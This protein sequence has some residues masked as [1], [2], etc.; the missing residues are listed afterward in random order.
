[1]E[2]LF[3]LAVTLD[4]VAAVVDQYCCS[5][6]N[7]ADAVPAASGPGQGCEAFERFRPVFDRQIQP[8][9]KKKIAQIVLASTTNNSILLG[10]P[11]C[12]VSLQW[13]WVLCAL[14]CLCRG[15][16]SQ[17]CQASGLVAFEA[18]VI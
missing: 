8:E 15:D 2:L 16:S 6:W 11:V 3:V 7:S 12:K 9:F 13:S 18:P 5:L 1:M 10:F 4:Q 17:A 14:P